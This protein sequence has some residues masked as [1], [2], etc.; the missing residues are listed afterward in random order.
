MVVRKRPGNRLPRPRRAGFA[1]PPHDRL[2]GAGQG[3]LRQIAEHDAK[4]AQ[5]ALGGNGPAHHS[6]PDD[7]HA[8]DGRPTAEATVSARS[9]RPHASSP[10]TFSR[11]GFVI[12]L[13]PAGCRCIRGPAGSYLGAC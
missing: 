3:F 5:Q 9:R 10:R 6:R 7:P 1:E 11:A 13:I 8:L 4:A 12:V 2:R